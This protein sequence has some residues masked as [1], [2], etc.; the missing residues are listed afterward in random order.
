[1]FTRVHSS[2]PIEQKKDAV[3]RH[4]YENNIRQL[5]KEKKVI[6]DTWKMICINDAIAE[7]N[8]LITDGNLSSY[9]NRLKAGAV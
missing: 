1:M 8:S 4:L 5:I 9:Y 3:Y 6:T 2:V 7:V